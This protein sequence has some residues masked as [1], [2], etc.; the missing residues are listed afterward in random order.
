M[1]DGGDLVRLEAKVDRL[2]EAVTRLVLFE[3]RQM[4]QGQHLA[5]VEARLKA[6]EVVVSS[7]VNRAIGVSALIGLAWTLFNGVKDVVLK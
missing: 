1:S 6:L 5:A 4:T 3:E 2:S 7:W